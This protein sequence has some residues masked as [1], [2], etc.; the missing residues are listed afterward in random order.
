MRNDILNNIENCGD[1]RA[2]PVKRMERAQS[3]AE[4]DYAMKP[5]IDLIRANLFKC[6]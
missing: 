4:S 6:N 5:W 3:K 2:G 1:Y